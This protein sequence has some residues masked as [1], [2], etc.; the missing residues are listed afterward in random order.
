MIIFNSQ[1]KFIFF[2]III[3]LIL[4]ISF[5]S[6][7]AC[8][9]DGDC[10][11]S[12]EKCH[13]I[14]NNIKGIC[15]P[16]TAIVV[17]PPSKHTEIQDLIKEFIKWLFILCLI[18]VP[19]MISIG[20]ACLIMSGGNQ[21]MIQTGKKIIIYTIIGFVIILIAGFVNQAIKTILGV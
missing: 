14:P 9:S 5:D 8:T 19:L 16:L 13:C 3:G 17:C 7:S 15:A 18:L 10:S 11:K 20:G 4:S 1:T 6:V 21:Q 12:G 2:L